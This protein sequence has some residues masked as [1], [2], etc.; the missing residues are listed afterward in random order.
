MT[1][2]GWIPTL[3]GKEIFNS[4]CSEFVSS[5]ERLPEELSDAVKNFV[6]REL[7]WNIDKSK[8][9]IVSNNLFDLKK[10]N[11]LIFLQFNKNSEIERITIV[12]GDFKGLI[13]ESSIAI[14]ARHCQ[15]N[16]K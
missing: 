2:Y 11:N 4:L 8:V 13:Q 14:I 3:A 12:E 1:C 10:S 5:S 7:V 9:L 6:E 15:N 16:K